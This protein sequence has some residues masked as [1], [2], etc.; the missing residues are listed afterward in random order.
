MSP[1]CDGAQ[2]RHALA[3]QAELLAGL[4][5]FLNGDAGFLA[6]DGRHFDF[7]AK[8]C[9]RH[10]NRHLAEKI[11]AV[12]LE[13]FMGADGEE[14]IKIAGGAA[15]QTR[16]ALI[17]KPDA[18]AVFHA[19]R[20]IDREIAFLG[21]AALAAAAAAGIGNNLAAALA[22]GAG[23]L[24]REEAGLRTHRACALA[25]G[26]G[27]GAGA[28]LGAGA[29]AGFAGDRSG[30]ADLR[31]LA[32][33]G[34]GQG[35]FHVVAEIGAARR[36]AAATS[37]LAGALAAATA[38]EI[39]EQVLENIRH[40]GIEFGAEAGAA[41]PMPAARAIF[42]GL[43]A[44]AVIGGFFLRI[45]QNIVGFADFLEL[46]FSGLVARIGIGMEF[47][48]VIAVGGLER[49]FVGSL[50]KPQNFVKITFC[51]LRPRPRIGRPPSLG[52]GG[53]ISVRT[54]SCRRHR[55]P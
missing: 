14:N 47:L 35:N 13:K 6:V 25:G 37:A 51:H 3:L 18:G 2:H 46:G 16:L 15:A 17:G 45:F 9:H 55:L 42:K 52:A 32:G 39:A 1:A 53:L 54:F 5:P 33:I 27:F 7:A 34:L 41:G 38:H 36:T 24:H 26:A 28:G 19:L 22:G 4:G 10:G 8:A 50:L 31:C 20:N 44:E 30:H 23:A 11:G 49:L 29:F 40:G 48:G 21:D 12:A 43:V